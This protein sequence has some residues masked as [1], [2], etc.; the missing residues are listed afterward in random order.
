M[1]KN[2]PLQNVFQRIRA[3]ALAIG[4]AALTGSSGAATGLGTATATVIESAT[5]IISPPPTEAGTLSTLPGTVFSIENFV[6]SLSLSGPLLRAGPADPFS[7]PIV[8]LSVTD[9][10]IVHVMRHADGSL[11]VSGGENLTFAVSRSGA[12]MVS[13]EYN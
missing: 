12:G 9:G 4:C 1:T 3:C 10:S 2:D 7:A 5:V 13:I 11:S 6:N 8:M